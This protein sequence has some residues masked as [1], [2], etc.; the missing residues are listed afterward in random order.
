VHGERQLLGELGMLEGQPAMFGAGWSM[1]GEL[2][3]VPVSSSRM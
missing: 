3:V 1:P 2:I